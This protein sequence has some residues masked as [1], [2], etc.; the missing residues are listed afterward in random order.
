MTTPA[1]KA[2]VFAVADEPYC[3][4]EHPFDTHNL[5]FLRGVD[6]EYFDAVGRMAGTEFQKTKEDEHRGA[7]VAR[8]ALHQG[9]ETLYSLLAAMLQAPKSVYAWLA[10]CSN[11]TL[12]DIVA[13]ISKGSFSEPMQL[14]GPTPTWELLAVYIFEDAGGDPELRATTARSFGDLWTRLAH[15]FVDPNT[16]QEYNSLKHGFRVAPGGFTMEI[17]GPSTTPDAGALQKIALGGSAHGVSYFHL[18]KIG[19]ENRTNR[20]IAGRLYRRNWSAPQTIL[21]LEL[22]SYSLR[23]VISRLQQ[24]NDVPSDAVRYCFPTEEQFAAP[25][26]HSVG[27]VGINMNRTMPMELVRATTKQELNDLLKGWRSQADAQAQ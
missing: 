15:D 22:V 25:W 3:V 13:S 26:A 20:S 1:V 7:T 8:L 11:Q 12:R 6:A 24:I 10:K 18:E 4:W 5:D 2:T 9:V 17:S 19:G 14:R 21:L 23:N 27:L 16:A